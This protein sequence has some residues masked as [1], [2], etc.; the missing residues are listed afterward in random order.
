M[1][2]EGTPEAIEAKGQGSMV[3]PPP[4]FS[5]EPLQPSRQLTQAF[6]QTSSTTTTTQ[7]LSTNTDKMKTEA[8]TGEAKSWGSTLFG[9]FEW[10]HKTSND[11]QIIQETEDNPMRYK[12]RSRRVSLITSDGAV[13]QFDVPQADSLQPTNAVQDQPPS[14]G[15]PFVQVGG[16][17]TSMMQDPSVHGMQGNVPTD[18]QCPPPSVGAMVNRRGG[19]RRASLTEIVE[20]ENIRAQTELTPEKLPII[21]EQTVVTETA[22]QSGRPLE[23]PNQDRSKKKTSVFDSWFFRGPEIRG[24]DETENDSGT[25]PSLGSPVDSPAESRKTS[26]AA[27]EGIGGGQLTSKI[28]KALEIRSPSRKESRQMNVWMPQGM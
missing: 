8:A 19:G 22:A 27:M 10:T 28:V 3:L 17:D 21:V 24:D 15:N 26:V 12:R 5:Q 25:I 18:D 1:S 16:A 6:G 9:H 11:Q 23:P 4:A 13:F 20:H 14:T 2:A 7:P